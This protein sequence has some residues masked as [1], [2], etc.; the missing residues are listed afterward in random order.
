MRRLP[1]EGKNKKAKRKIAEL[2]ALAGLG[3]HIYDL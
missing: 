1:Q 3:G 2:N